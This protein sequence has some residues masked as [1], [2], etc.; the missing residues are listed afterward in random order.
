MARFYTVLGRTI[1]GGRKVCG[2]RPFLSLFW[3]VTLLPLTRDEGTPRR[4]KLACE[5]ETGVGT[6]LTRAHYPGAARK[7]DTMRW[8]RKMLNRLRFPLPAA[9]FG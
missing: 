1:D 6:R 9:M 7:E 4:G 3:A 8:F 5:T 2:I